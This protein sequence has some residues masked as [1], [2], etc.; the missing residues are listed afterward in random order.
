MMGIFSIKME[1]KWMISVDCHALH[2]RVK[3]YRRNRTDL[4][5]VGCLWFLIGINEL[6]RFTLLGRSRQLGAR[7]ELV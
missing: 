4:G 3:L 5:R 7:P 6:P 2:H 1:S